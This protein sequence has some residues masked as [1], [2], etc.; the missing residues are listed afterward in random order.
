MVRVLTVRV[1]VLRDSASEL[2][3]LSDPGIDEKRPPLQDICAM[4][5]DGSLK[6][7]RRLVNL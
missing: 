4:C 2:G 7:H 1:D 3:S 5:A 6:S